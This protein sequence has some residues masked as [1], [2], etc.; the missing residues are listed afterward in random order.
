MRIV[1]LYPPPWKIAAEGRPPYPPG[2][3]P[4]PGLDPAA[5]EDGD[6]LRAPYG[7]LSLAGQAEAAGHEV[8]V[9]NLADFPWSD[10]E[11]L[12]ARVPGD[13]F[14]LSCL[15]VNRRGMAMLARLIRERHPNAHITVGGPHV[16]ALPI[17]TLR[18]VPA[19]DTVAVG[20]G[21]ETFMA[22]ARRLEKGLPVEGLPGTAWRRDGS[23]VRLGP[24][25]ARIRDLDRLADPARRF[26]L[27]LLLTSRGCPN[28][29]TTSSSSPRCTSTRAPRSS[30]SSA[31]A[32][33]CRRR[34]SSSATSSA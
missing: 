5:M 8:S 3:G 10:V 22:L 6:F 24:R 9:F 14:G 17:K 29:C 28:R 19:V 13:L 11:A 18:R 7:L 23:E 2:E 21:E 15:T 34:C 16:T 27:H 33:W 1:L 26:P 30:R 12:V 20:E 32:A 25:R 4:P 31:A